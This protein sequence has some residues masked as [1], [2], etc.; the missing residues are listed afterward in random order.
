MVTAFEVDGI[1]QQVREAGIDGFLPKPV[2]PSVLVDT[3]A[4]VFGKS[5]PA[6]GNRARERLRRVGGAATI[7]GAR[8]LL[9]EDNEIN[10]Q[11]AREIL[12]QAGAWVR[13]ARHGEEALVALDEEQFDAVL[14]DIQ[15]PEMDG[16]EATRKI[17]AHER[18]HAMP[19]IAMTA[20]AMTGDREKC[21]DAGMNDHVTKPVTAEELIALLARWIGPAEPPGDELAP[22][23]PMVVPNDTGRSLPAR[24]PGIDVYAALQRLGGKQKFFQKLLRMFAETYAHAGRDLRNA[25]NNGAIEDA[26]RLAHTLRGVAGS[27][28]AKQLQAAAGDLERDLKG[29]DDQAL[30]ASVPMFENALLEVLS[31]LQWLQDEGFLAERQRDNEPQPPDEADTARTYELVDKLAQQLDGGDLGARDSFA[32]L[33]PHLQRRAQAKDLSLLEQSIERYDLD[34]AATI[35]KRI[36]GPLPRAER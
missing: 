24:V 16:Y 18:F 8:I 29:L 11:V 2:Q 14:M 25:L 31:S 34:A 28:A 35:L 22:T 36:M 3:I 32:A 6:T 23:G 9:V 5:I 1:R 15:M 27:I 26:Q 30:Q 10:Q 12:E 19:V 4:E 20:H 17:R 33:R 21:M 7:R 13:V